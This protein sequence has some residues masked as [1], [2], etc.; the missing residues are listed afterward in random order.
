MRAAQSHTPFASN[1]AM[2]SRPLAGIPLFRPVEAVLGWTERQSATWCVQRD[3][4]N[5]GAAE[6][7]FTAACKAL[8]MA[9]ASKA[10]RR[11]RVAAA[12]RCLNQRRGTLIRARKALAASQITLA[13]LATAGA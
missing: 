13:K 2:M 1:P 9:N 5:L 10:M 8:G 6:A 7:A 3:T 4:N 11:T 12:F